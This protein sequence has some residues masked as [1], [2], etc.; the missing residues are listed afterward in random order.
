MKEENSSTREGYRPQG[1]TLTMRKNNCERDAS[2]LTR[3]AKIVRKIAKKSEIS[4]GTSSPR[5]YY[6]LA[7]SLDIVN[8]AVKSVLFLNV[9]VCSD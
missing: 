9:A 6:V 7:A 4:G 2:A 3:S 5:Q 8:K 1:D